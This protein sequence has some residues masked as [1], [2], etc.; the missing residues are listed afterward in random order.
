MSI[1]ILFE[2]S[3]ETVV[4]CINLSVFKC[5]DLLSRL[6]NVLLNKYFIKK[7]LKSKIKQIQINKKCVSNGKLNFLLSSVPYIKAASVAEIDLEIDVKACET[8]IPLPIIS[9]DSEFVM[10]IE[11]NEVP[12]VIK[13]TIDPLHTTKTNH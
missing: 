1:Y 5:S 10:Q 3:S 13:A 6:F 4:S 11:I 2:S 12:I 7:T 9:I 8:P